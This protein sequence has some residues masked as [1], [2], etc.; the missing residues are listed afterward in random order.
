[1][2]QDAEESNREPYQRGNTILE[3]N[4]GLLTTEIKKGIQQAAENSK[5]SDRLAASLNRFTLWLVIVGAAT[6]LALV[7]QI[8]VALWWHH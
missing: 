1:M 3:Q 5:S 4:L 7:T 6:F 8:V 2:K